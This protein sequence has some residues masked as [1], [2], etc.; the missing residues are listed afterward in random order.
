MW[1]DVSTPSEVA[2]APRL[3]EL[4]GVGGGSALAPQV[5]S[6]SSAVAHRFFRHH[7]A[8][9]YGMECEARSSTGLG[10]PPCR[11]TAAAERQE[12]CESSGRVGFPRRGWRWRVAVGACQIC[13]RPLLDRLLTAFGDQA[14]APTTGCGGSCPGIL[15]G[16]N[17]SGRCCEAEGGVTEGGG[18][19][20]GGPG[21]VWLG[22][23][24]SG[25]T[26]PALTW[27]ELA[28]PC[29]ATTNTTRCIRELARHGTPQEPYGG[30]RV[31][32]PAG[33]P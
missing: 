33:L 15:F 29:L 19:G 22:L 3:P 20:V 25:P 28:W 2:S 17:S 5:E 32:G 26:R 21:L 18:L 7:P 31:G 8:C 13:G 9:V 24:W 14:C 23:F 30:R 16:R 6:A 10:A 27:A 12:R 4:A 11:S 1:L